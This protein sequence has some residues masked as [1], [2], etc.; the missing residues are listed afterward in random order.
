MP[1]KGVVSEFLNFFRSTDPHHSPHPDN[2]EP[3]RPLCRFV[4]PDSSTPRWTST[5]C[6]VWRCL[7]LEVVD[8]SVAEGG[9]GLSHHATQ[10]RPWC[11]GFDG[12]TVHRSRR[13]SPCRSM[14][15]A[16]EWRSTWAPICTE[17]CMP[18]RVGN[19]NEKL[20]PLD[21]IDLSGAITL[22]VGRTYVKFSVCGAGGSGFR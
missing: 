20:A 6:T 8:E 1:V 11:S 3:C 14:L 17:S 9:S 18:E 21:K 12:A 2:T 19:L 10:P 13:A 16:K 15:V 7:G 5:R 4:D 22:P